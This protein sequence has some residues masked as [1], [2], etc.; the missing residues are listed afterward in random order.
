[1]CLFIG[2]V[3]ICSPG[4]PSI[5][6]PPALLFC[7]DYWCVT[8]TTLFILM[9]VELGPHHLGAVGKQGQVGL[10]A[11]QPI[12]QPNTNNASTPGLILHFPQEND[13]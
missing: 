12:S 10:F 13:F 11:S 3:S 7:M 5:Q 2:Q 4:W 1:M 6:G 8:T 9:V